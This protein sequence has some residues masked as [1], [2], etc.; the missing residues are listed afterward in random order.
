AGSNPTLG[1]VL[2][3]LK[4]VSSGGLSQL[5]LAVDA[6]GSTVALTTGQVAGLLTSTV[7]GSLGAALQAISS[8]VNDPLSVASYLGLLATPIGIGG[9]AL[10]GGINVVASLATNRLGL[11]STLVHGVTAQIGNAL[12]LVNGLLETGKTLTNVALLD[13]ALTAVQGIVSAPVT[14]ALAGIDGI[15]TAV[16]NAANFAIGRIAGGAS[17]ITTTWLGNGTTS[18][19]LQNALI[20]IGS[21]PLS[22]ASYTNAIGLLVGAGV[23]T[24]QTVIGTASSFASLPFRVGADLTGTTAAVINSFTS[25]LATA[26]SGLLQAAG[27]PTFIAGLPYAVSTAVSAAV[28]IAAFATSAA[29]N[30]ISA[31]IDFGQAIG[32]G[33]FHFASA[34]TAPQ[35]LAA[36]AGPAALPTAERHMTLV[37]V[38]TLDGEVQEKHDES[39]PAAST[40]E[41]ADSTSAPDAATGSAESVA[42]P[43]TNLKPT[44]EEPPSGTTPLSPSATEAPAESPVEKRN[45]DTTSAPPAGATGGGAVDT[46]SSA[47]PA[48]K[49]TTKGAAPAKGAVSKPDTK[50]GTRGATTGAGD[51]TGSGT[52]DTA[53]AEPATGTVTGRPESSGGTGR[54]AAPSAQEG[55]SAET[56]GSPS[57]SQGRHASGETAS[58]SSSTSGGRH[59]SESAASASTKSPSGETSGASSGA[60]GSERAAA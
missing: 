43:A 2:L 18:G 40:T 38:G 22:P 10:Q 16:S 50:P 4:A 45:P 26:A 21:A 54:H 29:L 1:S 34:A 9:L 53:T 35:A 30:A 44:A 13:G 31:A 58:A 57:E 33:I 8:V 47:Q 60:A 46:E 28:N 17:A 56:H 3:A 37:N 20:A 6:A 41:P 7:T 23:S 42:E 51:H 15:T 55:P 49:D 19:A 24:V 32:G 5:A 48:E 11:A 12:S 27:L 14:A 39:T 59:R 36:A 52:A 25:G